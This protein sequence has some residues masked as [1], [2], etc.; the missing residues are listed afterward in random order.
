MGG[1]VNPINKNLTWGQLALMN[2]EKIMAMASRFATK[3]NQTLEN[4]VHL[5]EDQIVGQWR[6]STYGK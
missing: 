1:S 6:D 5:K 3:G 2:A 4:L